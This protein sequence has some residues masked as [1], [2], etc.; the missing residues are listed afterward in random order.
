[1]GMS[2]GGPHALACA[3]RLPARVRSGALVSGLAPPDRPNPYQ[4]LP[5]PNRLLMMAGR[6]I[7]PLVH[8]IRR[9]SRAMNL[10]DPARAAGNVA[11]FFSEVDRKLVLEP[12]NRELFLANLQ[13]GYRQGSRGPAQD[14]IL[15]NSPWGFDLGKIST[16][17]DVWQGERDENVPLNQGLYQHERLPHSRLHVLPGQGHLYLL[18][19]WRDVLAALL[20]N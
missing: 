13:E 14:D 1:M 7:H 3:Y 15:I 10:G 16:P 8:L 2:A 17:I 5:L 18:A 20:E 4:G 9:L 19:F 12:G 11:S 6:H